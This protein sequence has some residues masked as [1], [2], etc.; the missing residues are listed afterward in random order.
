[1]EDSRIKSKKM[2][3]DRLARLFQFLEQSPDDSFLMF[4]IAKE[5]ESQGDDGQALSYYR[6]LVE[7]DPAYVG[8]YYH[9]GKLYERRQDA[10][11]ALRTYDQGIEA[12]R[13]AGDR[14]AMGELEG[15]K[16]QLREN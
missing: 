15:A 3:S 14:H 8:V 11:A 5:Y 2:N 4:A 16:L 7:R 6:R 9:L 1:M 13:R 10:E 12:A